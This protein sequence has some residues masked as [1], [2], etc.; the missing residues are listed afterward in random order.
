[1]GLTAI[2][3]LFRHVPRWPTLCWKRGL[4]LYHG[5]MRNSHNLLDPFAFP[6]AEERTMSQRREKGALLYPKQKGR[7]A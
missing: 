6:G 1:M 5:G 7:E 3:T 4:H 2:P